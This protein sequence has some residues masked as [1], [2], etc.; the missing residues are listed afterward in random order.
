MSEPERQGL[1]EE[2]EN[3]PI[4]QSL[5]F[6]EVA[7]LFSLPI[8]EAANILGVCSDV[9][10]KICRDNGVIRWP[11]RKF[12]AGKTV[13][14]IKRDAAREKNRELAELARARRKALMEGS[15]TIS[16]PCVPS[17]LGIQHQIKSVNPAKDVPKL[18]QG[19]TMASPL[20]KQQEAKPVQNVKPQTINPS[21]T[22]N[23]PTY[24]DEFMHGFPS[25][26]LSQVSNR[27]W[28]PSETKKA[29]EEETLAEE[30]NK[31]ESDRTQKTSKEEVLAKEMKEQQ[32][33]EQF[34]GSVN[35]VAVVTE[36][37]SNAETGSGSC[38]DGTV[39]LS[40]VR[41]R[42]AEEGREA[43]TR[44]VARSYG[45][46]KLSRKDQVLLTQVFQSS[47]PSKWN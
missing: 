11:Y 17:T 7:K 45:A 39:L 15:K 25:N 46:Y 4:N 3:V 47:F 6:N 29:S 2:S 31:V 12:I 43:L 42:A 28:S 19:G 36:D 20:L 30:T 23:I 14:D 34:D 33:E 1:S 37:K 40:S 9:L 5:S 21:T 44:G 18:Q 26:G 24:L 22:K 16:P 10:K 32:K 35:D 38:S 13:E 27:W 41:K 8:A